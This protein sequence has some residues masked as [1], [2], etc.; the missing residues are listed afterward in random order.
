VLIDLLTAP[1]A[2][3]VDAF[4]F[5]WS[6]LW[7]GRVPKGAGETIEEAIIDP[8][9]RQPMLL[10]MRDDVAVGCLASSRCRPMRAIIAATFLFY[11]SAGFFFATFTLFMLRDLRMTATLMGVIISIGGVSALPGSLAAQPLARRVGQGPAVVAG[12]VMASAGTMMLLS[13]AIL[14]AWSVV[15]MVLQQLLGDAGTMVFTILS[16]SLQ[17][18]LL[19]EDQLARANGFN[20]AITGLGMTVSIL[21]AGWD[22]EVIGVSNTA[23]VGAC[24]S[25]TGVIPLLT[26][27]LLSIREKLRRS[28]TLAAAD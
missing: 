8:T 27:P 3:I 26:R 28:E 17:Q 12:F 7:L 24:I 2:M 25:S 20:Q 15:F 10:R 5:I 22:A 18:L 21:T 13:A 6:A 9:P 11:V 19:P 16:V 23:I 14:P 1:V 4:T